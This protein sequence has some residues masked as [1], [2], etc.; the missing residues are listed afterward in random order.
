MGRRVGGA[1]GAGGAPRLPRRARDRSLGGTE[2]EIGEGAPALPLG[3][4]A[5]DA[6]YVSRLQD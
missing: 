4:E 6:L 5:T 1:L 2:V 3:P